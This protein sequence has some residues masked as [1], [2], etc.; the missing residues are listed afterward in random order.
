MIPLKPLKN[1]V[2][3]R[4]KCEP[5]LVDGW[6][7]TQEPFGVLLTNLRVDHLS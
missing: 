3:K 7:T 4:S 5:N 2:A 1:G 6:R